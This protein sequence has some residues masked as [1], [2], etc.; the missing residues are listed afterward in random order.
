MRLAA[1]TDANH[2]Q[3][4]AAL[5]AVGATV[6][7]LASIGRGCPDLLVGYK[8]KTV[9]IEVKDGSKAPSRRKLTDDQLQWH[10]KWQ[11]GPLAIVDSVESALRILKIIQS[12]EVNNEPI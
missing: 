9:L 4:V 12:T 2:S 8:Q 10:A 11:G 7:S 1:R 5:E 6:Q 3:I